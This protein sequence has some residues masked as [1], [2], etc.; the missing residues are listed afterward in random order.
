MSVLFCD[1]TGSTT[2]GEQQDPEQLRRVMT[3]YYEEARAVLER[4]GGTVEKFIG[5]AVMAVFGI[6]VLHEDDAVRAVR[7]AV[8]LRHAM[9]SLNDE[10]QAAFDVR[11][12]VR[13]GV[14]TGQVI[15]GDP[16]GGH[17]FVAGDA[18][19]VAQRLEAAAQ[20]GEILIGAETH[21]LARDAIV[22]EAMTPL[23]LKGKRDRVAA[24]RLFDVTPGAPGH[25]RRLDSP[26]VGRDREREL[27]AEA[28]ERVV[29]ESACRLVTILGPAGVGKSR[30]VAEALHGVG[31][32]ATVLSGS[33][34]PYG[35]GITFWP[36]LEIVK[37]AT[38]ISDEDSPG[39]WPREDRRGA[40]RRGGRRARRRPGR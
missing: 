3:R 23:E 36:V 35:E 2:I 6:P 34:L 4:H 17:S 32:R 31:G 12:E 30:L 29:D 10:L 28:F 22:A 14:N 5:D 18:V 7:A 19:N 24:Y 38:G 40:E 21:R 13:I 15:A 11:I 20:P 16:R 1:V 27:L 9:A 8:D 25:A 39:A 33:C 37:Q 26:M